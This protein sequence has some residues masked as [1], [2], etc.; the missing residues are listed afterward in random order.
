MRK[1]REREFEPFPDFFPPVAK[2]LCEKLLVRPPPLFPPGN[3]AGFLFSWLCCNSLS[4][5]CVCVRVYC[6]R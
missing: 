3:E 2:D 5:T 6:R 1:V 4:N